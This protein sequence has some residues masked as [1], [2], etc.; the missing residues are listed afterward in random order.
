MNPLSRLVVPDNQLPPIPSWFSGPPT[1]FR[2]LYA[3][4]D[5]INRRDVRV[6]R[7][8]RHLSVAALGV[9]L[10]GLL[11]G[12]YAEAAV[13]TAPRP[14]SVILIALLPVLCALTI[15]AVHVLEMRFADMGDDG[16]YA[17]TLQTHLHHIHLEMHPQDPDPVERLIL[18]DAQQWLSALAQQ[19]PIRPA[20]IGAGLR[21]GR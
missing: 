18:H 12:Q 21:L 8:L 20:L 1:A 10:S 14:A 2:E 19:R 7:Y 3:L 5:R 15:F 17:H 11:I 16:Y 4:R 13:T 6:A 9:L